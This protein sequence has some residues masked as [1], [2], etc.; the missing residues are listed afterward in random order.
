M[1]NAKAEQTA[2]ER[3]DVVARAGVHCWLLVGVC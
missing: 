3:R 2:V 1:I